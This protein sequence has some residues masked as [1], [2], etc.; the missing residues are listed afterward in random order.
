[1]VSRVGFCSHSVFALAGARRHDSQ[2]SP[3]M[4]RAYVRWLPLP[5]GRNCLFEIDVKL[6]AC[7]YHMD[8]SVRSRVHML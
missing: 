3:C 6:K 5:G 2:L 8:V 7:C 4:G 1:M